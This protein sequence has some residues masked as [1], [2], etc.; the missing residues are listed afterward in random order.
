MSNKLITIQLVLT[1]IVASQGIFY[2]FGAA[3]AYQKLPASVFFQQRLALDQV[4]ASR[5]KILYILVL[6]TGICA[7]ISLRVNPYSTPFIGTLAA[8]LLLTGDIV[9]AL[10]VSIPLNKEFTQASITDLANA[11]RLQTMWLDT[12]AIRGWLSTM[13]LISLLIAWAYR[14]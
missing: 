3:E 9:I 10:R 11:A 14:Q 5:L 2:L 6:I 12:I 1:I 4:L 13:A 7:M 8:T